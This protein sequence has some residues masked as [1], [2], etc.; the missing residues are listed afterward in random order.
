MNATIDVIN[1]EK[2]KI[3]KEKVI[4]LAKAVKGKDDAEMADVFRALKPELEKLG[5]AAKE[6]IG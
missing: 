2:E 4:A 3:V 5:V 6:V 1:E